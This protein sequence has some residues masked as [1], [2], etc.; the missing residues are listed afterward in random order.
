M[1]HDARMSGMTGRR[2]V[3][4]GLGLGGFRYDDI[5]KMKQR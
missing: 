4:R 3:R 5:A 2:S 1:R